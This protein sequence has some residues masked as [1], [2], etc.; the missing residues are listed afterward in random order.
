M[1]IPGFLEQIYMSFDF[2]K[3]GMILSVHSDGKGNKK[4]KKKKKGAT[5]ALDRSPDLKLPTKVM[6]SVV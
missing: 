2:R 4:K 1:S 3:R 6:A 5:M